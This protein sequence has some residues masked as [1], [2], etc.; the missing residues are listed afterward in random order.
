MKNFL[1]CAFL[2]AVAGFQIINLPIF[3]Q[4]IISVYFSLFGCF[5]NEVLLNLTII[6]VPVIFGLEPRLLQ[7]KRNNRGRD[8]RDDLDNSGYGIDVG[9]SITFTLQCM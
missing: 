4:I 1:P 8:V 9:H 5:C 7:C 3:F 2:S 6:F